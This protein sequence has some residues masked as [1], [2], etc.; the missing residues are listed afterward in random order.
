IKIIGGCNSEENRGH[1]IF[2]RRILIGGLAARDGRLCEGD[3]ILEVNGQSF[4]RR[5]TNERAVSVLRSASAT[6]TVQLVITRDEIARSEYL[7]LLENQSSY[8]YSTA[9]HS[10][11]SS[12]ANTPLMTAEFSEKRSWVLKDGQMTPVSQ[13]SRSRSTS[14]EEH[15]RSRGYNVG[16]GEE[17]EE[18]EEETETEKS[19]GSE[20]GSNSQSDTGTES[21][22]EEEGEEDDDTDSQGEQEEQGVVEPPRLN[23]QSALP[24][25]PNT[26]SLQRSLQ[27]LPAMASTPQGS[28]GVRKKVLQY[29]RNWFQR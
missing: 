1:G 8:S 16:D 18:E 2:V 26:S 11:S 27:E 25:V 19:E 17:D 20:A 12:R 4:G 15:G 6:S 10:A 23:T 24:K 3:E 29:S 22:G 5:T 14:P 13:S 21:Q 28:T 9:T 7:D